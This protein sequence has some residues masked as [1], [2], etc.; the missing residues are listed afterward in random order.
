ME[1]QPTE[2]L[3]NCA[4]ALTAR[5]KKMNLSAPIAKLMYMSRGF[6]GLHVSARMLSVA[7]TENQAKCTLELRAFT[8]RSKTLGGTF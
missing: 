2:L 5:K 7:G 3:F 6:P 1:L 8:S 4:W